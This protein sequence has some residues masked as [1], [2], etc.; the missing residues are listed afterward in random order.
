MLTTKGISAMCAFAVSAGTII[1][2]CGSSDSAAPAAGTGGSGGSS[3][4]TASAGSAGSGGS[5]G[6]GASTGSAGTAG[7]AAG[8]AA[9]GANAGPG[10]SGGS[11][12]SGGG[13]GPGGSTG[14]A[15]NAGSSGS[16]GS[17]GGAAGSSGSSGAP[18]CAIA[19]DGCTGKVNGC[20]DA[21]CATQL[22]ACKKDGACKAA[23]TAVG[24]CICNAQGG[25]GTIDSCVATFEQS[26]GQL[27]KAI[28]DCIT[29]SCK[30]VCGL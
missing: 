2:A 13:A 16:S 26:S 11:A 25:Q 27:A 12:G 5:A 21:T 8:S 4:G 24:Q 7:G 15:G 10:G 3:G 29:N 28:V 9:G 30:S 19:S 6:A 18:T 22:A 20:F 14:S 17:G 1:V 23:N